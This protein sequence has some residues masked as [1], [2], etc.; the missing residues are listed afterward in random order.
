[1]YPSILGLHNVM[2]W[3]VLLAGA[4]AVLLA[5][6]GWLGRGTWTDREGRAMKIFVGTLDLQFAVG[7]LL[8]AVFSPLT[9]AAFSNFGAAM[10]DAAVRYFVV[11][12]VVIMIAAIAVA[13]VGVGRVKKASTDAERFQRAS[14]W[15]G[16]A[17]AA[18]AGFVPWARPLIPSF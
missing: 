5:W 11:E 8:Y 4:W 10:R 16:L 17:F 18:V 7:L 3:V 15:L 6:R 14:V 9:R 1:M 13:H 2:R 12:H